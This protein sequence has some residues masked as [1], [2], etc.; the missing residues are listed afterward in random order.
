MLLNDR[1]IPSSVRSSLISRI[2]LLTRTGWVC[3]E[4]YVTD[5]SSAGRLVSELE[6]SALVDEIAFRVAGNGRKFGKDNSFG[7]RCL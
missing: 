7:G 1:W 6:S 2:D 4:S 5:S 3:N